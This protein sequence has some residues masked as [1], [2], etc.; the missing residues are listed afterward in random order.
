[1]AYDVYSLTGFVVDVRDHKEFDKVFTFFS[2][3]QGFVDIYATSIS[4]P[5]SKLRSFIVRY[6]YLDIEI[7]HGKTGYRLIRARSNENGFLVHKKE[8]YFLLNKFCNLLKNLIPKN[9]P[10]SLAFMVLV[11][12]TNHILNNVITSSDVEK[13]F[14]IKALELFSAMGYR[15]KDKSL[16]NISVFEMKTEY[17]SILDENGLTN[18][19]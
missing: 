16:E 18:M 19:I 11:S 1:M 10:D 17:E 4:K 15:E 6:C 12:L 13:I 9:V 5:E 7:V 14:L 8:A 2:K 3:E